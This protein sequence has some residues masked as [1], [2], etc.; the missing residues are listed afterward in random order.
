[1]IRPVMMYGSETWAIKKEQE[2]RL[3]VAEIK[4]IRWSMG[5]TRKDKVRNDNLR[6]AMGIRAIS[7]KI[8]ETGSDGMGMCKAAIM[9]IVE[10]LQNKSISKA[11]DDEDDH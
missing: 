7:E 5:K 6:N 10:K 1:M 9:I 4:M 3:D 8:Q 11:N 2:R